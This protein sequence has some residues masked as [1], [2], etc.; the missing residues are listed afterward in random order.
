MWELD[1]RGMCTP[2]VDDGSSSPEF[3]AEDADV[4]VPLVH[5][6]TNS[7][8]FPVLLIG[9]QTVGFPF[10]TQNTVNPPELIG[11]T[12]S[13]R[14]MFEGI[15]GLHVSGELDKLIRSAGAIIGGGKKKKGR[16]F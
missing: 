6:L 11:Q 9:G 13:A 1:A 3:L 14:S 2:E 4:I 10:T 12:M 5:R 7:T 15:K 16:Y 8:E